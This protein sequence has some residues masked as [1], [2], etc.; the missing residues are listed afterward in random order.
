MK[1]LNIILLLSFLANVAGQA[2]GVIDM[3]TNQRLNR[4][5]LSTGSVTL[6]STT[7]VSLTSPSGFIASAADSTVVLMSLPDLGGAA[8]H[9][10]DA[11][12]VRIR[13]LAYDAGL[14][15]VTFD[16][17]VPSICICHL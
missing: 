17:K 12:S 7:W 4:P 13:N 10:G 3:M 9:Q 5:W 8:Y 15:R 6:D 16:A 2:S 1:S 11:T 14:K